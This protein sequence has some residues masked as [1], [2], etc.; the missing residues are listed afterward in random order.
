VFRT[1]PRIAA[2]SAIQP[3]LPA[4]VGLNA[5]VRD[6]LRPLALGVCVLQTLLASADAATR[7]ADHGIGLT[8]AEFSFP[9][10][11]LVLYLL[12]G[13]LTPP[14][15]WANAV[16]ALVAFIA[17]AAC[18]V[19]PDFLANQFDSWGIALTM[20]GAGC[21]LLSWFWLPLVVA[22]GLGGWL[23]VTLIL[24]PG[25]NWT[26]AFLMQFS[27]AFM[28]A[29]I[30]R[31]RLDA[32]QRAERIG[33]TLRLNE[34][35]FR[36]LVEHST[37]GLALISEEGLILQIGS[38]GERILGSRAAE[39][40]GRSAFE[41]LHP[42][43]QEASRRS[44]RQVVQYPRVPVPLVCR[45][46]RAPGDSIR[47][48]AVVTNL[49]DEPS[50]GAIVINFRDISER[51][52][53]EQELRRAM[54]AAEAANLAKGEFLANMSHEI[55]TPMNGVLGM[56]DLLLDT[57]LSLEQRDYA[58]LVKASAD[59]L[60][61]IIDDILDFSKIEARKLDLEPIEFKLRDSV[62]LAIK[63]IALRA[64]QKGLALL[65]D[66]QPGVPDDLIGDPSRLRQVMLNLL[67]NAIKFTEQGE[68]EL[69]VAADLIE[70][71]HVQLH[72]IVRDTGIGIP[73]AKLQTIFEAFSQADGSTARKFGGTGLGL[74]ISTRLVQ[75]MGG[76]IWVESALGQ[77]SSFHFTANMGVATAVNLSQTAAGQ[78]QAGQPMADLSALIAE[79]SV[80]E[81]PR[82]AHVLLAE[83]NA[84]NQ[85]IAVRLLEKRGYDVTVVTNG[86]QALAAIDGGQFDLVLMDI[87][88]PEMDGLETASAIRAREMSTGKRLPIVAMTAHAMQGDRE[89]CLAAGMDGYISKPID[90]AELFEV[91]ETHCTPILVR[92]SPVEAVLLSEYPPPS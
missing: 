73:Q 83:D 91:V 77:G 74:T 46:L 59:S 10:V 76:T 4:H 70:N 60:L 66:I 86:K 75:M 5:V 58:S 17:L 47:V 87:Q 88:M 53:A 81:N 39:L 11:L 49:L 64:R 34:E 36:K 37:D 61:T 23:A 82:R 50:V 20:V 72:F 32:L 2:P 12:L 35:R 78:I 80:L 41:F 30:M 52:Q 63:I 24:A 31:I 19:P 21:F 42:D 71:G 8:L 57:A 67:G 38:S 26:Q 92:R 15:E 44:L 55:R 51:Y 14:L 79:H 48:E 62:R 65:Y 33:E 1:A 68:V 45:F 25:S 13:R 6:S 40:V 89:R 56:T 28:A 3:I 69:K 22:A 54:A 84:V 27:S 90:P 85:T 29:V 9:L 7:L 43:D 18:F 16:A